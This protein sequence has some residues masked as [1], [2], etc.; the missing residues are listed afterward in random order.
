MEKVTLSTLLP[1]SL[2]Q[3]LRAYA[4]R[5]RYDAVLTWG[6]PLSLFFAL[7]LKLTGSR[8]RHIALMY[9]VSPPKKALFLKLVHSHIDQIITWSSVQRD[10][11]VDRLGI[12]AAKITLVRH[13]VDQRFWRPMAS[14]ADM[15]CAVGNEM[16]DYGT[17]VRA[18]RGLTIRCHIAARDVPSGASPKLATVASILA[19]GPMPPNVTIG[20][21]SSRELRALYARSRFVVIPLRPTDTD[22]GV[23][24]ALESMAMGKAV[25]CSRTQ[26]QVDVIEDGITGLF[27]PQGN[28][29]ALRE[30]IQYLS[31]HPEVAE[32]MGK[33]GRKRVEDRHTLD[34]FVETV[35]DVVEHVIA[36]R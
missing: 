19:E 25:I 7:L 12:P 30:A 21:K 2:G 4:R 27:V 29:E 34:E 36:L 8:T 17:L 23:S 33:A 11:A 22:N 20:A 26:G 35:K 3:V 15:I 10:I 5:Q 9:W 6:E 14:T 31:A 28:P 18:M 13:P 1:G 24:V 16:R 32:R